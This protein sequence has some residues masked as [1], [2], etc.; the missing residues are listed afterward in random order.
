MTQEALAHEAGVTVS[1]LSLIERGHSN[2]TWGTVRR[3][4]EALD[5]S[6]GELASSSDQLD[7][8][9]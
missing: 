4:A 8:N 6:M 5:V 2:P 1:H 3:I 9:G 7:P